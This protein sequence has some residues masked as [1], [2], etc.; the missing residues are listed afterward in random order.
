[1]AKKKIPARTTVLSKADFQFQRRNRLSLGLTSNDRKTPR[2]ERCSSITATYQIGAAAPGL[3]NI[4][5]RRLSFRE[6]P[7]AVA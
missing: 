2:A 4:A 3:Q 1:L 7:N 6:P 5:A